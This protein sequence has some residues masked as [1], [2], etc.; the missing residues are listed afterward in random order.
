MEIRREI[1]GPVRE[2]GGKEYSNCV[3][4]HFREG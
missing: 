3:V 4:P 2:D 1:G